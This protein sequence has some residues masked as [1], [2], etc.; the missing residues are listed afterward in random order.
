VFEIVD[1]WAVVVQYG[2]GMSILRCQA[3]SRSRNEEGKSPDM[4]R[5]QE[6]ECNR[7]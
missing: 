3:G 2:T 1:F 7:I 4:I 5:E 6:K